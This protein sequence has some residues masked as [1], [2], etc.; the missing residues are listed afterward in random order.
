MSF[1][2]VLMENA[3]PT[4]KVG[5]NLTT[6][7]TVTGSLRNGTSILDPEILIESSLSTDMLSRVNYARIELWHRYYYVTDIT[8]D[9]TGLWLL[10]MHVDVLETY[11]QEISSQ[12][13]I[14]ARQEHKYNMYFD[15]GWFM[16]YQNPI[17]NTPFFSATA[18]FE[19]QSFILVVAG[20]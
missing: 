6:V 9:I 3:S 13:C 11:K 4:N 2:I 15:D 1:P 20:S 19:Q 8:L 16:S 14:V 10:A 7:E 5:K 12:T 18:P 17:V